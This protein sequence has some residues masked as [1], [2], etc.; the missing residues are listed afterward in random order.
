MPIDELLKLSRDAAKRAN[1]AMAAERARAGPGWGARAQAAAASPIAEIAEHSRAVQRFRAIDG[2]L[3]DRQRGLRLLR[4]DT[5]SPPE[6]RRRKTAELETEIASLKTERRELEDEVR[7]I[8]LPALP[9]M[10]PELP[11]EEEQ[12]ASLPAGI[13]TPPGAGDEAVYLE[14]PDPALPT[15]PEDDEPGDG[16]EPSALDKGLKKADDTFLPAEYPSDEAIKVFRDSTGYGLTRGEGG[17]TLTDPSGREL[18]DLPEEEVA[19][20]ARSWTPEIARRVEA[21]GALW[22]EDL[23]PAE[24]RRLIEAEIY[25]DIPGAR[26]GAAPAE[27]DWTTMEGGDPE[28]FQRRAAVAKLKA[29]DALAAALERGAP[30]EEIGERVEDFQAAMLPEVF[31]SGRFFRELL[32]DVVPGLGNVRSVRHLQ[33]DIA[34][35]ERAIE[36]GEWGDAA[37]ASGMAVLDA[38]GI[39]P[40]GNLLKAGGRR[41]AKAVPHLDGLLAERTIR[42]LKA[43]WDSLGDRAPNAREIF[44]DIL[45]R[46]S[47]ADIKR[48]D[49]LVSNRFGIAGG[50]RRLNDLGVRM[51]PDAEAQFGVNLP[52][53]LGFKTRKRIYDLR[54][55][56]RSDIIAEKN[57]LLGRLAQWFVGAERRAVRGKTMPTAFESK[58]ARGRLTR[59]A[60]NADTYSRNNP[61][62]AEQKGFR[63]VENLRMHKEDV[64]IDFVINDLPTN[65]DRWVKRRKL[66]RDEADLLMLAMRQMKAYGTDNMPVENY[67]TLLVR[68]GASQLRRA[69]PDETGFMDTPTG[70]S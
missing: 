61:K 35:I 65:L 41:L 70:M 23:S 19:E 11:M 10:K 46:F 22:R 64:P 13:P 9:R 12:A 21:M 39:L 14:A 36:T 3:D 25:R 34:E 52:K 59:A 40:G 57:A 55:H 4:Q 8:L 45:D 53:G 28:D 18:F 51:D 17:F 6:M 33:N 2:R 7:T 15:G 24:K 63:D 43:Q 29:Y 62:F 31:G 58:S 56:F 32:M 47:R 42:R 49:G 27:P 5:T 1:A 60:N 16:E 67:A 54:A 69:G 48:L 68:L 66:S 50:E 38:I 20:L 26:G 30:D 44:G 37:M